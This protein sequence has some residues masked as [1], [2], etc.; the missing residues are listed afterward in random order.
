MAIMGA[1]KIVVGVRDQVRARKFWSETLGFAVTTDAPYSDGERWVEVTSPDG[2]V[3][4]ILTPDP[5][6]RYRVSDNERIPNANPFF[7]TDDIERTYQELSEKGV[8][9]PVRP[10]REPWGWWSMFTDSEGNR[11]ALQQ[12]AADTG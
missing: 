2:G 6:Y 5:E 12:R 9:F 4:L 10:S 1:E 8:E 7:Y 11:F 3:A